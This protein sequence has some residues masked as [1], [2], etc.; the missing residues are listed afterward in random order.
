LAKEKLTVV[1]NDR[2][3]KRHDETAGV[4]MKEEALGD[5]R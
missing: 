1:I 5:A 4:L 3:R 2:P